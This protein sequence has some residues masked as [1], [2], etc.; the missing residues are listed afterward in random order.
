MIVCNRIMNFIKEKIMVLKTFKMKDVEET[1][2]D[3]VVEDTLVPDVR[4]VEERPG[5]YDQ[6]TYA[7]CRNSLTHNFELLVLNFNY[8]DGKVKPTFEIAKDKNG[9]LIETQDRDACVA[10]FKIHI[11][12]SGQIG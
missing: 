3:S 9:N 11:A 5:Y 2:V 7:I 6:T 10:E 4:P 8:E 1:K 12:R